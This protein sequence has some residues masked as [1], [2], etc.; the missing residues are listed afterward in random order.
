MAA[1]KKRKN[2]TAHVK[3]EAHISNC[4]ILSL[5]FFI[6][7]FCFHFQGERHLCVPFIQPSML[8]KK[9]KFSSLLRQVSIEINSFFLF[10]SPC[11]HRWLQM[12]T[13]PR[14]EKNETFLFMTS[15][16]SL[17]ISF[18]R[19]YIGCITGSLPLHKEDLDCLNL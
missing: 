9:L 17:E 7:C 16:E 14:T 19:V 1:L 3:L 10:L 18:S 8:S 2:Q 13:K 5:L 11:F 4:L 12:D 15:R 6:I